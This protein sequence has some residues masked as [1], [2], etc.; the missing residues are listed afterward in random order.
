MDS[1]IKTKFT[2]IDFIKSKTKTL[3]M[4]LSFRSDYGNLNA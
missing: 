4:L 1:L 2:H 3:T